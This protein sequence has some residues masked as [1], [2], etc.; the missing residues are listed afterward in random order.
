MQVDSLPSEPPGKPK[1]TG[2]GSLSLLKGIFLSQESNQGLLLCRLVVYQLRYQ[3][4]DYIKSL[5]DIVTI[6][7]ND[8]LKAHGYTGAS[9]RVSNKKV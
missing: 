7:L 1:K 3:V 2:V 6:S 5:K 8:F 9:K 4:L